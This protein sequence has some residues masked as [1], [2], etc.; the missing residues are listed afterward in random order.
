MTGQKKKTHDEE[1]TD[2]EEE[3]GE[4]DNPCVKSDFSLESVS[5]KTTYLC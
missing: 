1:N 4:A 3:E 2:D 5:E